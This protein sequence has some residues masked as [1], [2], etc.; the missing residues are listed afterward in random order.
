MKPPK[1]TNQNKK[2][3]IFSSGNRTHLDSSN[4]SKENTNRPD[5]TVDTESTKHVAVTMSIVE[6]AI[7][8]QK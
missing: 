7:K 4:G 1:E 2:L 8:R 3:I 6:A 5:D